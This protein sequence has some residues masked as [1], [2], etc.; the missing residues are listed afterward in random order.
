M[1]KT[2]QYFEALLDQNKPAQVLKE[3]GKTS[4]K[5]WQKLFILAEAKRMLGSFEEAIKNYQQA[6]KN[7][8]KNSAEDKIDLLLALA[9]CERTLG[10]AAN[11]YKNAN[12]AQ[13]L[14]QKA[15]L[16]DFA[17]LALQE[18]ALALRAQGKLQDAKV[19]LNT[20]LNYYQEQGELAGESFIYWA[21][22]GISRLEGNFKQGILEFKKAIS[23]A[24]KAK[25]NIAVAYA[26][27]G[28]AGIS[29][30]AGNI[31]DCVK[32]YQLAAKLFKNT[33]DIFGKAYTNC[34]L[35]NGLRQLGNYKTAMKHYLVAD[36]LYSSINDTV[37]LG[38]VKWGKADI[39]K[40]Q[41]KLKESLKTLLEAQKLFSSSDEI[42]GQLLTE[43]SLAQIYY[44][45]GQKKLADTIYEKAFARAKKEGLRTYL[46]SLT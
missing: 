46:E 14:A 35:A 5:D 30:I 43:I 1:Q 12:L 44:L 6:L 15:E 25:D 22:G 39:L 38:F 20:T 19:L 8:S 7:I 13:K 11:A 29:R 27:C 45:Q 32:N 28:L 3:L 37:D 34:G 2:A 31:K 21:L 40:H 33:D 10:R 23:L 17:F 9:K 16:E 26:V 36:K 18:K 24:R 4:T 41:G 42:R